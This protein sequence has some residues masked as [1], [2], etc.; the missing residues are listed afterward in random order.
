MAIDGSVIANVILVD[1]V[2]EAGSAVRRAIELGGR[3]YVGVELRGAEAAELRRWLDDA[4]YESLSFI[5]GARLERQRR[6]RARKDRRG[7]A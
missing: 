4:A 7:G 2:E 3:A 6:L 1:G 5:L